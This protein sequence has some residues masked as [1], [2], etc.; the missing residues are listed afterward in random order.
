MP[1]SGNKLEVNQIRG[2][3]SA[4]QPI[5]IS[6]GDGSHTGSA[7]PVIQA[8]FT[9]L[10]DA[11]ATLT[12]PQHCGSLDMT[13]TAGRA[14]TT[15]TGAQLDAYYAGD[16]PIGAS[17]QLV[18]NNKAAATHA[19]TLTAGASGVVVS[20]TAAVAANTVGIFQVYKEAA[21]TFLF[22]RLDA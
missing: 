3:G 6:G 18:I 8:G 7:A 21:D 4:A 13:P 1:L 11:A 10:S 14:V 17:W 12:G 16:L 20:G 15:L 9:A 19:I 22:R 2:K 5:S